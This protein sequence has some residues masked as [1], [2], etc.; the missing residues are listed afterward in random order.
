MR[1]KRTYNR[2][3]TLFTI[4]FLILISLLI[5]QYANI[6]PTDY[7]ILKI[8]R[9]CIVS[10]SSDKYIFSEKNKNIKANNT[11]QLSFVLETIS[12]D[13]MTTNYYGTIPQVRIKGCIYPVTPLPDKNK[14]PLTIYWYKV[15][16]CPH[17]TGYNNYT[18]DRHA[19]RGWDAIKYTEYEVTEWRDQW[20]VP[21]NV[22]SKY[23]P[24]SRTGYGTMR[25]KVTIRYC[26]NTISSPGKRSLTRSGISR[27]VHRISVR[28]DN[29]Y[30]GYLISMINLPYIYG[31]HQEYEPY[32]STHQA[33]RFIGMDCCDFAVAG[34]RLFHNKKKIPYT[35]SEFLWRWHFGN[36]QESPW[37]VYRH[38]HIVYKGSGTRMR[39]KWGRNG[40]QPGDAIVYNMSKKPFEPPKG[41]LDHTA[42]LF[43]DRSSIWSAERGTGNGILD[44]TD[45]IIQMHM[46]RIMYS[47]VFDFYPENLED[48]EFCILRWL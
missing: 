21:V 39:L 41:R 28:P 35:S 11:A 38:E 27:R 33:E 37:G 7:S 6:S 8:N 3:F 4:T 25:Y 36:R 29:S 47:P 10:R 44:K 30:I 43:Q 45:V 13:G 1:R 40:I 31:S 5:L 42:V 9:V 20:E 17:P 24:E 46:T 22:L 32:M 19:W 48:I 12:T 14:G 15:E 34:R 23:Y 18:P 16:S 2:T 26:G